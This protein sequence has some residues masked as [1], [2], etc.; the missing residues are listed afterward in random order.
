MSD[1]IIHFQQDRSNFFKQDKTID[2]QID[3]IIEALLLAAERPI[4]STEISGWLD[5]EELK[6]KQTLRNMQDGYK[7]ER[8]GFELIETESGWQ[9]QTNPMHAKYVQKM[10]AI[11]PTK[12]SKASL[13]TLAIIAYEQ[14][15]TKVEI[16][17]FRQRD[18][19]AVLRNLLEL[20][21]IHVLGKKQETG[22]PLIYGTTPDFLHLFG[23]R[24]LIELP[25]LEDLATLNN[26]QNDHSEE[27]SLHSR[28]QGKRI[29]IVSN[30]QQENHAGFSDWSPHPNTNK[31]QQETSSSDNAE[32]LEQLGWLF[33][34]DIF[35]KEDSTPVENKSQISDPKRTHSRFEFQHMFLQTGNRDEKKFD[36]TEDSSTKDEVETF[37]IEKVNIDQI[38][39]EQIS[40][41]KQYWGN[42]TS[43]NQEDSSEDDT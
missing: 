10:L 4:T 1:N 13:D 18:C 29:S 14:P 39:I 31:L 30:A 8:R 38:N 6:V 36:I 22:S 27:Q 12:L 9:F 16:D 37:K 11:E 35:A 40:I 3:G 7:L 5:F 34:T 43:L 24:D 32:E 19:G 42:S 26:S 17:Q 23:I 15:I 41:Q 20:S 21:L 2:D 33:H 25:R 28:R